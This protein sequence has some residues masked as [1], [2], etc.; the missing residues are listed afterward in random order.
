MIVYLLV[1]QINGKSYVGQT[2]YAMLT[3]RWRP[4][5]ST[6]SA[7][8]HLKAAIS[9]YGGQSFTRTILAHASCQTELDLL[10]KFFITIFQTCNPRYGYN[11]QAGGLTGVGRHSQESIR[12]ISEANKRHWGKKSREEMVV[13]AENAR[14]RWD[15]WPEEKKRQWTET[16]RARWWGRSKEPRSDYRTCPK[17]QAWT[18]AYRS[19]L[20]QRTSWLERRSAEKP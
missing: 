14:L 9:K 19:G 8:S 20:E 13:Y 5:L 12:R 18:K 17:E 7:N 16:C 2:Q 6:N 10:E 11:Q 4:S 15:M 1:N 3:R